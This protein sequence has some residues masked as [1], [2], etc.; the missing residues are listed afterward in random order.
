[1]VHITPKFLIA[2]FI[3]CMP[4][5]IYARSLHI[6]NGYSV[7]FTTVKHTTP[8]LNILTSNGERFYGAAYTAPIPPNVLHIL[9]ANNQEYFI[10]PWCEAGT[11]LRHDANECAPCGIGHFCTGGRHRESCTYG[12]IA[13]NGTNHTFDPPMPSGTSGMYNRALTMTEVNQYIPETDIEEWE[14][15][16]AG[17]T[18]QQIGSLGDFPCGSSPNDSRLVAID[19]TIQPGTYIVAHEYGAENSTGVIS[20]VSG[21]PDFV[22]TAYIVIFDHDVVYRPIH[23]CGRFYNY[24]DTLHV[25][26][27][28]WNL[29]FPYSY[30]ETNEN[31]TNVNNMSKVMNYHYGLY[32]YKLK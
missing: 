4:F 14:K 23:M 1:M 16:F 7:E 21:R 32:L 19:K 24:F 12:V 22:S 26:F 27:Q 31:L 2:V 11:Y 17:E 20:S 10:G 6:G 13:C 5:G 3:I 25:P 15:I 28:E 29:R 9:T 30:Y 8:S 18:S